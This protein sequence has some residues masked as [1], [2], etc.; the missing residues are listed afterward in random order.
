MLL[1]PLPL[2]RSTAVAP[3]RQVP[4]AV[5]AAAAPATISELLTAPQRWPHSDRFRS[6]PVVAAT[7]RDLAAALERVRSQFHVYGAEMAVSW[8]GDR[9]W[10]D[11]SGVMRDGKQPLTADQP[12][13][14]G[15]IT[16][17]FTASLIL[18]LIHEGRLA[19]DAQ[20]SDYL[21][22]EP[23]LDGITVRELL[24]HT[25]GLADLYV[26][27]SESL[28]T[29]PDEVWTPDQVLRRI[30]QKWFEPGT[31]WGYSNTNYVVLGLLAERVTG[32]P[33]AK[34]LDERFFRPL[35]LD[36]TRLISTDGGTLLDPAW[37]TAFWTAGAVCSSA[38]DLVRWG[39]AL[40]GGQVLDSTSLRQMLTFN[41]DDYGLGARRLELGDH[42]GVGHTGLLA[43][44]TAILVHLPAERV[45]VALIVNRSQVD[46]AGMLVARV[47]DKPSLLDAVLAAR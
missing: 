18:Q 19:L 4:A 3:V 13:V 8:D 38:S 43:T 14:I 22:D 45:T 42:V 35:G 9:T 46:V 24:S 17:T 20:V 36:Q 41:D 11:A 15:S 26:P 7:A 21:P 27:L 1:A 5:V 12:L 47:G 28:L 33:V 25:S 23:G 31:A 29:K 39:D 2:P 40:Y 6:R 30:G 34:L 44:Y 10:S 37:A 32:E 16:K